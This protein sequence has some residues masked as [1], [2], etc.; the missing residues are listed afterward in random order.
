MPATHRPIVFVHGLWLH[1]SS[2]KPWLEMF[3]EA[4]YRPTAPGWPNEP[5]SVVEARERP[6]LV[7]NMGIDD[8]V[9]HYRAFVEKL[10]EPPILIGHSFGGLIVEKMLGLGI[11]R[12]GVAIDP[13]QIKGVLRLPFVQ[14]RSAMP[15]LANPMNVTRSVSLSASEFRYGFGNALSEEESDDLYA[16]WAIPSPARPMFQAAIANLVPN[17]AA[18]VD[19]GNPKRG[20][21]LMISGTADHTVP[22]ATTESAFRLYH[23]S[24]VTELI[25]FEGR[26]H[27]LTID[28]GWRDVASSCMNWLRRKGH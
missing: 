2:W 21:L 11:G 9:D 23:G 22:D 15:A 5:P 19:T 26:G 16:R 13:A 12:A 28:H 24:A 6:E 8:V 7:A 3:E 10:D 27:S 18:A 14:L 25:R 1:T 4:G 17:S 20:P